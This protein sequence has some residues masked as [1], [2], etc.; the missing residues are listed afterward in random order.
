M[1]VAGQEATSATTPRT[2]PL[3][4]RLRGG[5]RLRDGHTLYWWLEVAF[6]AVFYVVYST[7][8]NLNDAST[9]LALHH[10]RQIIHLQLDLG[11]FHE[12]TIQA[13][14]LHVRP[15]IIGPTTSTGPCTSS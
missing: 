11:I 12:E 14:A 4:R 10:A 6:V 2:A 8:R 7:I 1:S 15:L 5:R 9:E 13:W 3:H